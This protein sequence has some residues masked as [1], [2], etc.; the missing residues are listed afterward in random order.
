MQTYVERDVK[1]IINIKDQDQFQ[2]FLNLSV[3]LVGQLIDYSSMAN[4][5]GVA[6]E[7]IKSWFSVLQ[8]SFITMTLPPYFEN[9]G[10]RIIKSSKLYFTD[11]G[12]VSYLLG[13]QEPDQIA[14]H[15]LR[16]AL[17][18][19]LVVLEIM[20]LHYNRGDDTRFYFYRDSN[21]KE[22]DIL[23]QQGMHLNAVE[24]KSST[25]FNKNFLKPLKKF[26]DLAQSKNIQ[27]FLIYA[28]EREQMINHDSV[29]NYLHLDDYL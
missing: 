25:T 5:L 12:L 27:S 16:G 9:F 20:K 29:I 23:F 24:I 19:N 8:A 11:L 26:N 13:I 14:H 7:T 4:D 28:G 2:R 17:F 18:E 21:Q 15:P 3:T 6:R 10:K 22:V 1:K